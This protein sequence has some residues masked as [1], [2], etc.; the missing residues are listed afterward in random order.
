MQIK[1]D[2]LDK[3]LFEPFILLFKL[4]ISK[5]VFCP[6]I[7]G[8]NMSLCAIM[9]V[10]IFQCS[11]WDAPSFDNI[12]LDLE[13]SKFLLHIPQARSPPALPLLRHLLVQQN[14]LK[15]FLPIDD[16]CFRKLGYLLRVRELPSRGD[17][18]SLQRSKL[19]LEFGPQGRRTIPPR[20]GGFL[21]L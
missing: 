16:A 10:M 6:R 3:R 11:R 18:V 21:I 2:E 4:Y 20:T 9:G 7:F 1:T 12:H 19:G 8:G 15:L 17:Q 14:H 5:R 13:N